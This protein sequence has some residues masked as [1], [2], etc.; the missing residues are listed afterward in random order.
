MYINRIRTKTSAKATIAEEKND[1]KKR[2]KK[3][4]VIQ[5]NN[6]KKQ[7]TTKFREVKS[8]KTVNRKR[9]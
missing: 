4:K 2:I 8:T 7:T 6:E 1:I 3:K 9:N 5:K